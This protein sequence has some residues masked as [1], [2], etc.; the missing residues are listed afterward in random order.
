M[1]AELHLPVKKNNFQ[2]RNGKMSIF[3]ADFSALTE[4]LSTRYLI[5]AVLLALPDETL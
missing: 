1:N 3:N 4:I 2:T 5:A